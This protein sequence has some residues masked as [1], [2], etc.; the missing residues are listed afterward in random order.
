MVRRLAVSLILLACIL[1]VLEPA[2][3]CVSSSECCPDGCSGQTQQ[4]SG[5]VEMAGC[6]A[7]QAPVAASFSIAPQSREALNVTGSSPALVT[8]ADDPLRLVPTREIRT[9]QAASTSRSDQ[10]L[11]YLRTARLRL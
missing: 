7:I 5:W 6:C 3:A 11:T 2:F 8:L 10:S 9:A 1:G 4:G